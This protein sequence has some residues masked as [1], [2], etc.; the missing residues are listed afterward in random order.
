M[1]ATNLHYPNVVLKRGTY[2]VVK[3]EAVNLCQLNHPN[4][5]SVYAV[6]RSPELGDNGEP[7]GYMVMERLGPSLRAIIDCDQM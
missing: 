2:D 5:A 7:M 3:R 1:A 6:L 4:I